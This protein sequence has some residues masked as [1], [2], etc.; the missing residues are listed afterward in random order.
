M[1]AEW[2]RE[3][4]IPALGLHLKLKYNDPANI[5]KGGR[6]VVDFKIPAMLAPLAMGV[7]DLQ[8]DAMVTGTDVIKSL[9]D[10][11]VAYRMTRNA[12]VKEGT[13]EFARTLIEN[14]FVNK[15]VV[16][17]MEVAVEDVKVNTDFKNMLT[18]SCNVNGKA[19]GAKLERQGPMVFSVSLMVNGN[20]VFLTD[21]TV[22]TTLTNTAATLAINYHKSVY[23]IKVER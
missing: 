4:D 16:N 13:V 12:V 15:L 21:F 19:F 5:L 2:D 22:D 11:K 23:G 3:I 17:G 7:T 1:T 18:V 9:F 6:I 10:V 8:L 20:E 14:E